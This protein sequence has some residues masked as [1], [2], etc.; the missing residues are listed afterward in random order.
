M[1]HLQTFEAFKIGKKGKIKKD[2]RAGQGGTVKVFGSVMDKD[3]SLF[4]LLEK[5]CKRFDVK[6]VKYRKSGEFGMAFLADDDKVIKLTSNK[7]E[8]SN[9]NQLIDKNVPGT[10]KYYDI[11]YFR[12]FDI[13]AILME[14]VEP[15]KGEERKLYQIMFDAFEN[16]VAPAPERY[17]ECCVGYVMYETRRR[18]SKSDVE[19]CYKLLTE[20]K[21]KLES[22]GVST[23]DLH[24]GN[25]GWRNG[26]LVHFDIMSENT[27][28]ED[29]SKI[30]RIKMGR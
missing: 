17:E 21:T 22:S 15:L 16:V 24:T 9:I 5:A 13:Y 29:I 7:S 23:N 2:Y 27:R 11:V 8:A 25:M 4:D 14:R 3:G 20:L 6:K 26:E 1:L 19:K 12:K 18:Y 30:S 10:I 28:Q